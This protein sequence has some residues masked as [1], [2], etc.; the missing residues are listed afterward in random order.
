MDDEEE[1]EEEELI[2]GEVMAS[3][4][5][6]ARLN[7]MLP[8]NIR[9]QREDIVRKNIE[10][11]NRNKKKKRPRKNWTIPR[12]GGRDRRKNKEGEFETEP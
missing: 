5:H 6:A 1:E 7:C 3:T 11:R 2:K 8:P 9:L 4:Y 12:E 10:Q